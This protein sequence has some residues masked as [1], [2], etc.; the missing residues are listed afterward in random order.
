MYAV[1]SMPLLNRTLAIFLS[2]ELGF[3][4]FVM[5]T[6][7]HTPFIAGLCTSCGD[8][9]LRAFWPTRHPLNTWLKVAH[10]DGV[11]MNVLRLVAPLNCEGRTNADFCGRKDGGGIRMRRRRNVRGIFPVCG[12]MMRMKEVEKRWRRGRS[13]GETSMPRLGIAF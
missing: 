7:K 13:L 10:C 4:G 6:R 1:T 11:A 8:T 2:P 12:W 9:F 3:F 5:P